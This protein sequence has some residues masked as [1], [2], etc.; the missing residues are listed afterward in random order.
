MLRGEDVFRRL[1]LCK[2]EDEERFGS[3]HA[4][5][6]IRY[7]RIDGK[8]RIFRRMDVAEHSESKRIIIGAGELFDIRQFDDGDELLRRFRIDFPLVAQLSFSGFI[9]VLSNIAQI[10]AVIVGN[11]ERDDGANARL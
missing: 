6:K 9:G 11:L 8:T 10:D 2:S 4:I 1:L 7:I 5:R 3:R